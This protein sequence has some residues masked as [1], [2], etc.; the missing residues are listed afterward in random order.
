MY[1]KMAAESVVLRSSLCFLRSKFGKIAMKPLKSM[2]L[3]FYDTEELY[4]AKRRLISDVHDMKLDIVTPYIP[5]RRDGDSKAVRI[6]DDLFTLLVFLDENQKLNLLPRYVADSPD[7]MPSTRLYE[8]DLA[9]LMKV[10]ERLESQVKSLSAAMSAMMRDMGQ[11]SYNSVQ[12][13]PSVERAVINSD[14]PIGDANRGQQG[15]TSDVGAVMTSRDSRRQVEDTQPVRCDRTIR[16]WADIAAS[17]PI[18]VQNR[19]SALTT[20]DDD[21]HRAGPFIEQRSRRKRP[22]NHSSQSPQQ[23]QQQQRSSAAQTRDTQQL[24][25]QR[26]GGRRRGRVMLTGK[27]TTDQQFVAAKR[28]FK[29][30]VFCVDNV[31]PSLDADDLKRFV[32]SLH[33]QVISCFSVHPRRRRNESGHVTDRKAFRL[34]I[35]EADQERLL[36]DSKWPESVIISDWYYLN[37][38]ER[39][40]RSSAVINDDT[41]NAAAAAGDVATSVEPM[42]SDETDDDVIR[43][44]IESREGDHENTVLYRSDNTLLKVVD[45]RATVNHGDQS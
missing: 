16:D 28:I 23:R 30:A 21:D 8:G 1:N 32:S 40:Q 39:R 19:Y 45:N 31:A 35:N 33:V 41:V 37:P 42:V 44:D 14:P 18:A 15:N 11:R 26:Q 10:I 38:A 12:P 5:E 22:R 7:S 25:Q 43:D 13:L 2:A 24:Q 4:E 6:V 36:D 29:K 9:I 20:D 27:S 3:D 17:T 34:C